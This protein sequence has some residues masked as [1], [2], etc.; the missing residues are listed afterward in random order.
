MNLDGFLAPVSTGSLGLDA[1]TGTGGILANTSKGTAVVLYGD[2][3]GVTALVYSMKEPMVYVDAKRLVLTDEPD[4]GVCELVRPHT[5]TVLD[6]PDAL[7]GS[8]NPGTNH[9]SRLLRHATS[10]K[11]PGAIL[12]LAYSFT[13]NYRCGRAPQLYT[14]LRVHLHEYPH[15]VVAHVTKNKFGPRDGTAT[16]QLDLDGGVYEKNNPTPYGEA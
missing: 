7:V 3:A 1:A 12:V 5:M 13:G 2:P 15:C 4:G 6:N 11:V 10:P 9:L 14:S 8:S 16:F